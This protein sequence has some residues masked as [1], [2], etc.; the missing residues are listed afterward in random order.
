MNLLTNDYYITYEFKVFID[1]TCISW[2][3]LQA[4]YHSRIVCFIMND[5]TGTFYK[6]L[7]NCSQKLFV[8]NILIL[9]VFY[10]IF[11][12][13]DFSS[14]PFDFR[15]QKRD[16]GSAQRSLNRYSC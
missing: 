11:R 15:L 12:L 5:I 10:A 13:T 8:A 2:L 9:F 6:I 4:E 14:D 3:H 7:V 1:N 16:R